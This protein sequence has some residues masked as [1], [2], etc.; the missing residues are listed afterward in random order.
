MKVLVTGATGRTGSEVV[1]ALLQR[2]VDVRALTR[3]QL[4][5]GTLPSAVEIALGDLTD[6]VST[7]EALKG[8]DK[9]FLLIAGVPDEIVQALTAYS[10]S[11]RAGL[12]HVTYL[13]VYRANRFLEVPHFAAKYAVEEAIRAGRMP[14]TTLRP[15]Y[16]VQNERGLKAALTDT[17][18][19]PIPAGN[20]GV[21]VTDVRDIAEVAA[22]SLTEEGHEGKTYDLVS[23]DM[24]TGPGAAATWSKLLGK[25]IT[26]AGHGDFDNFEARMRRTGNPLRETANP[27]SWLAHDL[28][29]MFEGFVERGFR[30]TEDQTA[31]VAALLGR[32][33][34]T[35]SGYA[36]ELAA[37]W[38]AA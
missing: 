29:L 33:P 38:A 24:L 4:K 32:P 19:Y 37:E 21:A 25:E 9:L 17:G 23:S 30:N 13:S 26:Y 5:P 1:K 3:K 14:Y 10:L 20:L 18:V 12:K 22:I 16:F 11:K 28:R 27:L 2:G 35:Y 6:P 31:R 7:A 34:R 15:A 8:V 36:E